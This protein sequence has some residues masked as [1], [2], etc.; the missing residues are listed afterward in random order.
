MHRELTKENFNQIDLREQLKKLKQEGIWYVNE[1][2]KRENLKVFKHHVVYN[3]DF[4]FELKY[5]AKTVAKQTEDRVFEKDIYI[6]GVIEISK[7]DKIHIE[8]GEILSSPFITVTENGQDWEDYVSESG[9]ES[10]F[11]DY[12]EYGESPDNILDNILYYCYQCV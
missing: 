3:Q 10:H 1:L 11:Y 2:V 7:G 9:S 6:D 4:K 8:K 5:H 12:E